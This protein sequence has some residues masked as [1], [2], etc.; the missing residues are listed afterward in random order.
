[1][2]KNCACYDAVWGNAVALHLK[3]H[4]STLPSEFENNNSREIKNPV[5][6]RGAFER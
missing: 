2:Y 3:L 6:R 1:M 5:F 4:S